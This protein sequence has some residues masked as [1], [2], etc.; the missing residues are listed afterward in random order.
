MYAFWIVAE[1]N[2]CCFLCSIDKNTRKFFICKIIYHQETFQLRACKRLFI[3]VE[4]IVCLLVKEKHVVKLVNL[5]RSCL[6]KISLNTFE[7][8][9][10][11]L[12]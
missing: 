1:L 12:Y 2:S 3:A 5:H 4:R 8:V 9:L 7:T 11:L 6:C 10:K